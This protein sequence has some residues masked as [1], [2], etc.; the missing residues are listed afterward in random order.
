MTFN[1]YHLLFEGRSW[2][3]SLRSTTFVYLLVMYTFPLSTETLKADAAVI[4]TDYKTYMIV[5]YCAPDVRKCFKRVDVYSRMPFASPSLR[6]YLDKFIV[7]RL[8]L[9][10]DKFL[11]TQVRDAKRKYFICNSE[12][13][14]QD[15][16]E[17]ISYLLFSLANTFLRF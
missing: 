5:D 16:T 12:L 15:V 1:W 2:M 4:T 17:I 7:K 10:L 13:S 3:H 8:G 14:I 9:N 11:Y 6:K